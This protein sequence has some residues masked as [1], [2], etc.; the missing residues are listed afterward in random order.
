MPSLTYVRFTWNGKEMV[1]QALEITFAVF[2]PD[3][4]TAHGL[5]INGTIVTK[6][7]TRSS[8]ISLEPGCSL[9]LRQHLIDVPFS[10]TTPRQPIVSSTDWDTLEVPRKLLKQDDCRQMKLF[11]LLVNDT[12][13]EEAFHEGLKLSQQQLRLLHAQL[14]EQFEVNR[15]QNA[16]IIGMV[17]ALVFI[18][19][20]VLLLCWCS[21]YWCNPFQGR[22]HRQNLPRNLNDV[23]MP[24][25][26]DPEQQHYHPNFDYA[27]RHAA[28]F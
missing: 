24:E 9:Q 1:M 22:R 7:I 21:R 3:P 25:I 11:Q 8:I 28:A 10:L 26:P 19:A 6:I 14:S 13:E 20:T 4:F 23:A 18:I 2:S 17:S 12:H 16:I 27:Q 5:G 15:N